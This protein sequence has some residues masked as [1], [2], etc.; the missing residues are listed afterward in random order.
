M[1]QTKATR[2]GPQF[3]K[4]LVFLLSGLSFTNIHDSQGRM[5][6]GG[7]FFKSSLPFL[8]ASPILRH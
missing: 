8:P 6:V 5:E 1:E 3:N 4:R 2:K 7:Y